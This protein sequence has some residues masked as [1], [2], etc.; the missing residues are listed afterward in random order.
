MNFG[1]SKSYLQPIQGYIPFLYKEKLYLAYLVKY[2]GED[3]E[4]DL[5]IMYGDYTTFYNSFKKKSSNPIKS[6][7]KK[8]VNFILPY[9]YDCDN[10][11]NVKKST[12]KFYE[13]I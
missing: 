7:L 6:L 5:E 10:Y 11:V 2:I 3:M 8:I 9:T 1:D 4:G 13:K 12:I